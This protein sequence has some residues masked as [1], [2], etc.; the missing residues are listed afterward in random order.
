RPTAPRPLPY[1]PLFRAPAELVALT[2]QA[3]FNRLGAVREAFARWPGEIACVLVEP[4][5]GNMGCV[6]PVPGFLEGLRELCDAHGALLVLDR[7]STR[8]NSSHVKNS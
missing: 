3:P 6:P 8:L 1:T 5:A 4:V 7:K 2:V